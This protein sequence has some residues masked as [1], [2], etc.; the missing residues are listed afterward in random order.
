[1]LRFMKNKILIPLLIAG[2]LGTFFSFTYSNADTVDTQK[3]RELVLKTVSKAIKEGH[4]SPR[5]VDDSLSNM[6][7]TKVLAWDYDKKL[8]TQQEVNQL[9]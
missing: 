6:V 1:M 2:A 9:E 4:Y 3:R 5:G 8:F 7:Y